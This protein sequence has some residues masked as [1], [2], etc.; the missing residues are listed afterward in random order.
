MKIH[1]TL[2]MNKVLKT[3]SVLCLSALLT[4]AAEAREFRVSSFEPA[5]GFFSSKVLTP[6]IEQVNA[7]LSEGNRFR[8]YPGSILGAPPAQQELVKKGVADVALVV[9]GY[10]PG[11]FPLTSIAEVPRI[12]PTSAEGTQVLNQLLAEG[13]LQKEYDD[14]KVI[15][16]F[17]THGYR[18][19]SREKAVRVP[20]DMQ[21][22]KLRTPSPYVSKLVSMLGGS[23]V[24]IPA[25]QVYENLDRG[26]VDGVLWVLDAYKTFRLN[27]VAPQLTMTQLT[28]SPL[29]ILMNKAT[30]SALSDAD[31]KV[32]DELSGEATSRW[33]ASVIDNYDADIETLM[34]NNSNVSFNDPLSA[35]E[36]AQWDKAL[37]GAENEWLEIQK[38]FGVDGLPVLQQAQKIRQLN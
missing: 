12:A 38:S 30:Y 8:L 37:S 35:Q 26:V 9:Q 28:A 31:K 2:M 11:L 32:I 33:V 3:G 15:A 21:G 36:V 14:Y 22:M 13:A 29:A 18:V 24:S 10:S 25:P 5:Q 16:L 23:G 6:W 34:R 4:V 7:R 27:E 17:T 1:T 19:F 20:A